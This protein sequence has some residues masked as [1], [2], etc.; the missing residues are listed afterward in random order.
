MA[1]KYYAV[2]KEES[3]ESMIPG[4]NARLRQPDFL[5]QCLNLSNL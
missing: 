5:A 1:E 4:M 3:P 2:K